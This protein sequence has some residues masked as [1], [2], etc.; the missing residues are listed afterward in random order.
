MAKLTTEQKTTVIR[1]LVEGVSIRSTE[2]LTG[3]H[4]DTIGRLL[5]AVGESCERMMADEIRHV[6]CD[7]LQLDEV[8][9]FVGKKRNHVRYSDDPSKVGD[10]WTWVAI[11]PDTKLVP[12]H[13]VGKRDMF[14]AREF[15]M[16]LRRRVEGRVQISTDKLAAYRYAIASAFGADV[17][18]GRIVKRYKVEPASFGR[19]SPPVVV[20]VE[21]DVVFGNPD[22]EKISTSIVERSNLTMR[23][24]I[25]R[26]TRLTL[27][28]SKRVE[29]LQA[30]INLHFAYYNFCRP[31]ATDQEG[32][33]CDGGRAGGAEV[34]SRRVGDVG[35]LGAL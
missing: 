12:H 1:T 15:T 29:S 31:H 7:Q 2:R 26:M 17:D 6:R 10:F 25:R 13:Y 11:D 9:N 33:A 21:K 18:Y 24:Q 27:G 32:D 22:V 4:R 19:Y 35:V 16:E 5:R 30:A 23:T 3:I 14:E 8:W 28:F 34:G 20:G